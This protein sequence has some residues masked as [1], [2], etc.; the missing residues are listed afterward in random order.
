MLNRKKVTIRKENYEMIRIVVEMR[1]N[2]GK[3]I[4]E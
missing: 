4:N 2:N 3:S 1:M